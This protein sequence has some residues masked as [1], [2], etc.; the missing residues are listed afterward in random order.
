M[1]SVMSGRILPIGAKCWLALL[2]SGYLAVGA[3]LAHPFLHA[4]HGGPDGHGNPSGMV[5]QAAAGD[6]IEHDCLICHF[7]G[8]SHVVLFT[9]PPLVA[10]IVLTDVSLGG[11]SVSYVQL[12][13]IPIVPR[14]PPLGLCPPSA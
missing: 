3:P 11:H 1:V 13:T 7:L 6:A 8:I 12:P 9:P 5:I 4:H 14:G 10:A 2:A